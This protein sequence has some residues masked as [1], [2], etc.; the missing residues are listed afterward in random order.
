M[1]D[2]TLHRRQDDKLAS[3]H[4]GAGIQVKD[5]VMVFMIVV[6][7]MST[8][9]ALENKVNTNASDFRGELKLLI[10]AQENDEK[11]DIRHIMHGHTQTKDAVTKIDKDV[12]LIQR[13]I[14]SMNTNIKKI[15]DELKK[16]NQ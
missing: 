7:V 13:D 6:G 16:R 8:F 12:G 14:Q 10:Q 3:R 2:E 1:S 5:I 11:D 9:F 4:I 15:F